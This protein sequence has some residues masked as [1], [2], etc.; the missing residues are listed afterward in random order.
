MSYTFWNT[1][2]FFQICEQYAVNYTISLNATK[3]QLLYLSYLDKHQSD[4]LNLTMK[5]GNCRPY[6]SKCLHLGTT[7]YTMLYRD[8]V[9]DVV[10]E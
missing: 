3:S 10:N 9:I 5:Y 8:N 2:F 4:L 7:I 6:E 1:I